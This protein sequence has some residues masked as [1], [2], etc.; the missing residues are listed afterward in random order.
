M[1]CFKLDLRKPTF[2]AVVEELRL[3]KEVYAVRSTQYST[4]HTEQPLLARC[5]PYA[6]RCT[7][8]TLVTKAGPMG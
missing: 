8:C 4:E 7:S 3:E 2:E 5:S 1:P 6:V